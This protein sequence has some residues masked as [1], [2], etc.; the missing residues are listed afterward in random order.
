MTILVAD[1]DAVSRRVLELK[2]AAWGHNAVVCTDGHEAL[3]WLTRSDGPTIAILD[4]VMPGVSGPDVCRQVRQSAITEPRYLLL[5]TGRTDRDEVV[6]GLKSGADDYVTKPF[7]DAELEARVAVGLRVV[8]LQSA[9]ANRLKELE[10]ALS[11]VNQLQ[12]LLP[13]CAYCKRVRGDRDYW[14]QVETYISEH[15]EVRF[16]HGVCPQCVEKILKD[17]VNND[18]IGTS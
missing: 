2:L 9:L 4:W 17:E 18:D 12:G 14:S 13:I 10:E 16:T 5:L 6:A 7:D 3:A 8:G 1:D 15:S 11:R